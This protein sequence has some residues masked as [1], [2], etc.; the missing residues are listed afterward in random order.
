MGKRRTKKQQKELEQ[1]LQ[2]IILI[3]AGISYYFTRNIY[4]TGAVV[5]IAIFAMI[6]FAALKSNKEKERLRMSGIKDIDLMD[7]IQ[8]EYY[9]KELYLSRGY[10]VEVTS[11]SGDF[12]A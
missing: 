5:I 8:F 11:A 4:V 10:A 7:G 3:V 2:A 6:G 12:G 9:L 1:G